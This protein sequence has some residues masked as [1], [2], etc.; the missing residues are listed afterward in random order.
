MPTKIQPFNLQPTSSETKIRSTAQL[1]TQTSCFEFTK[2]GGG[3]ASSD[4]DPDHDLEEPLNGVEMTQTTCAQCI[5]IRLFIIIL[6]TSLLLVCSILI[7]LTGF[8]MSQQALNSMSSE[9]MATYGQSII[10]F[11]DGQVRPYIAATHSVADDYN[12]GLVGRAPPLSYLYKKYSTFKPYGIGLVFD[13]ELN[14]FNTFGVPPNEVAAYYQTPKGQ[15]ILNTWSVNTTSPNVTIN[16]LYK[17]TSNYLTTKQSYWITAFGLFEKHP[18]MEGVFGSSIYYVPGG[19]Y[20]MYYCAKLYDPSIYFNT[21]NKVVVGVAKTNLAVNIIQRF[22]SKVTLFG[23]GYLLVAE[24]NDLVIGGNINTTALDKVSRVSMFDLEDRDSGKLMQK[25][26][27]TYGDLNMAPA[28]FEMNSVGVDYFIS[29]FEF[30]LLNLQWHVFMVL[31]RDEVQ[32]ALNISSGVSVAVT[33]IIIIFGVAISFAIGVIITRPFKVLEREFGKI[34]TMDLEHVM[35]SQSKLKEV[36][37]IYGYLFEM[38]AWLNEIKSFIPESVFLQLKNAKHEETKRVQ[39]FEKKQI[40][41][42]EL[43]SKNSRNFSAIGSHFSGFSRNCPD[44]G[45]SNL[46]KMGLNVKK[47]AVIRITLP[48]FSK[49]YSAAII[50]H[51]FSK[52]VS[53]LSTISKAIQADFSISSVE[54]FQIIVSADESPNKKTINIQSL[55]AALKFSKLIQT[56]NDTSQLNIK[57]CIGVSV[58]KANVGNLGCAS[59]R[60]FSVVGGIL[61]NAKR[62][63][64]LAN[65]LNCKILTDPGCL[66]SQTR[67]YFVSRPV[68]R[69]L[70]EPPIYE[71]C[72]A[73]VS[74]CISTVFEVEKER[75]VESDEWMYEL[76]QHKANEKFSDFCKYFVFDQDYSQLGNSLLVET[77]KQTEQ[78]LK[79]EVEIQLSGDVIA[80]RLLRSIQTFIGRSHDLEKHHVKLSDAL[81]NYYTKLDTSM[82]EVFP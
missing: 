56:I 60:S 27:I 38:T 12:I 61:E 73:T 19:G 72:Q 59:F 75:S 10:R 3:I 77:L 39:L 14:T 49:S 22:L 29:R 71:N 54:E 76:Q 37:I 81:L 78:Q 46:F 50:S 16:G 25:I 40:S 21:G 58:G 67:Q 2:E 23:T 35:I 52:I 5:S 13:D 68:E 70:M 43:Q 7:W 65:L 17:I 62:L 55:D 33:F 51:V 6:M 45:A 80:L 74:G 28:H 53:G 57:C 8:V 47:T 24:D 32:E 44:P 41:V 26:S 31:K 9:L 1:S 30:Q 15:P 63:S 69:L 42:T 36:D 82:L 66:D 79:D 4:Y 18:E 64:K 34:K 20:T 48:G 11:M